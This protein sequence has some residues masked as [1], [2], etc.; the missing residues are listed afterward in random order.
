MGEKLEESLK[1][2][3]TFA[4]RLLVSHL[5]E[6]CVGTQGFDTHSCPHP[7]TR[8]GSLRRPNHVAVPS[9]RAPLPT[10]PFLPLSAP[11]HDQ[12]CWGCGER[13]GVAAP[14]RRGESYGTAILLLLAAE[15]SVPQQFVPPSR[16]GSAHCISRHARNP[17]HAARQINLSGGKN[18]SEASRRRQEREIYRYVLLLIIGT[19]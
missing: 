19:L 17:P 10:S 6:L 9:A 8:G 18:R 2:M 4:R 13:W 16:T 14:A 11:L 1:W 5:S 12:R 3:N 15:Q 7:E